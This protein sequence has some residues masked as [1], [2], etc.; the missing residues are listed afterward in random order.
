MAVWGLGPL[1]VLQ[2][3]VCLTRCKQ[4]KLEADQFTRGGGPQERGKEWPKMKTGGAVGRRTR[5]GR[6]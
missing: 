1:R 4:P 2:H 3:N 5:E 6:G